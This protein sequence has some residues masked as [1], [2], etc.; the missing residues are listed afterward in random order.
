MVVEGIQERRNA[1]RA[2]EPKG[3]FKNGEQTDR[4]AFRPFKAGSLHRAE[5]AFSVESCAAALS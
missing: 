4:L 1:N 2:G 5:Q 3:C